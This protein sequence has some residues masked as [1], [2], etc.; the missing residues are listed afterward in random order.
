MFTA[1]KLGIRFCLLK[2]SDDQKGEI[3]TRTLLYMILVRRSVNS[4]ILWCKLRGGVLISGF[5]P[6]SL[7]KWLIHTAARGAHCRR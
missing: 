7:G 1:I 4:T 5:S 2:I 3:G 6:S